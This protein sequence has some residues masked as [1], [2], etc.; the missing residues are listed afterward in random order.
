MCVQKD[1]KETMRGVTDTI[2]SKSFT[3]TCPADAG[4]GGSVYERVMM[5]GRS[6]VACVYDIY[7]YIYIYTHIYMCIY[8][9]I[10]IYAYIHTYIHT[11][12]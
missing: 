8:V 6:L 7:I 3:I 4:A 12:T 11:Y 1:T 5:S 10:Y 9:C 2:R